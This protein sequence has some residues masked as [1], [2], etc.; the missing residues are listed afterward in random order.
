MQITEN[1]KEKGQLQLDRI[2]QAMDEMRVQ[3]ALGRAEAKDLFEKERKTLSKF[4]NEEKALLEKSNEVSVS[5]EK[6]LLTKIDDLEQKL[7][8]VVPANQTEFDT[9][10]KDVLGSIYQLEYAIKTESNDIRQSLQKK[11]NDFKVKMDG[12]RLQL[13]LSKVE[14]SPALQA[15]KEELVQKIEEIQ[16]MVENKKAQNQKVENFYQEVAESYSHFKKA[17]SDLLGTEK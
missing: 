16:S 17:F 3:A 7:V 2:K 5:H 1:L 8:Q 4:I 10:K 15:R 9:Y 14:D 12:Y 11:F 6:D 13:A